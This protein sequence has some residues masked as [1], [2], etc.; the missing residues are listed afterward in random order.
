MHP[1]RIGSIIGFAKRLKNQKKDKNGKL[2]PKR[3]KSEEELIQLQTQKLKN[4]E[5][6]DLWENTE[7]KLRFRKFPW[8]HWILAALFLG[9]AGFIIFMV[10]DDMLK[11]KKKYTEAMLLLFLI[12]TGMAFLTSGRVKSTIFD[13]Q[14]KKLTIRKRTIFC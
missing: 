7:T 1:G 8:H 14:S 3:R 12:V 11:F 5:D 10:I 13:K 2:I 9:A 4:I 6:Q